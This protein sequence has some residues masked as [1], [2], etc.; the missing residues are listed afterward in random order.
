[1]DDLDRLYSRLIHN[2]RGG[3]PEL[4][5]RTFEVSQIYQQIVPYRTNRREL[6][7]DS[8]DEYE[9]ALLQ[10]LAGL[11][12]YVT[13]D[14]E[15]QKAMRLELASPNPD[16]SAFRVYATSVIALAPDAVRAFD[17][18]P[19]SEAAM[20]R[21]AGGVSSPS[22][23]EL[24]VMAARATEAVDITDAGPLSLPTAQAPAPESSSL[25]LRPSSGPPPLRRPAP[26][27]DSALSR[28]ERAPSDRSLLSGERSMSA[29]SPSPSR[30]SV[31]DSCRYC[32]GM[33]PD[34][35]RVTF[36]PGCGHNLTVQHCPA[37]AT[38]LE[39][40]WKFCITCGREVG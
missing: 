19:P 10:L 29:P 6:C 17:R 12:G 34:G 14:A 27:G 1:M 4:L 9:L 39:V 23:S 8:N 5:G 38:E 31:G 3:F 15:L 30:A 36:C 11:R 13:G 33:L 21:G 18:L 40:G 32:S 26:V 22:P 28:P 25:S 7:F 20:G 16:L 24:A 35:R 37:C 2:V